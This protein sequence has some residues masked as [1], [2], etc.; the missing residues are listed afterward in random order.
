MIT[1][2]TFRDSQENNRK[3]HYFK[4]NATRKSRIPSDRKKMSFESLGSDGADEIKI[5]LGKYS[6]DRNEKEER[7]GEGKAVLPSG[8][9]YQGQYQ[10]G[11]RH[12]FGKYKFVSKKA[13]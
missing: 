2:R 4:V 6:G 3:A 11:R 7:H 8:D 5:D 12:G 13:R 9:E 1:L 10:N